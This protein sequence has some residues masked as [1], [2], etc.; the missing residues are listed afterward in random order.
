[1]QTSLH[2][3]VKRTSF[4]LLLII[5]FTS[6]SLEEK[7]QMTR[8]KGQKQ[9]E[10][11]VEIMRQSFDNVMVDYCI[12]HYY[13]HWERDIQKWAWLLISGIVCSGDVGLKW[14]LVDTLTMDIVDDY[15]TTKHSPDNVH[16]C[17]SISHIQPQQGS[18][19]IRRYGWTHV[20]S[21]DVHSVEKGG[22]VKALTY[23]PQSHNLNFLQPQST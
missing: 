19:V 11:H 3:S 2:W 12:K 13:R 22:Y 9:T 21:D 8:H 16:V 17:V 6:C 20:P 4:S 14:T 5:E 7:W 10:T 23:T 18:H 15:C 1:M